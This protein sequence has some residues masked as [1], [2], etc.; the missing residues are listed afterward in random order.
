MIIDFYENFI[1][2]EFLRDKIYHFSFPGSSA[3]LN[4]VIISHFLKKNLDQDYLLRDN[5]N[6]NL[7][8]YILNIQKKHENNFRKVIKFFQNNDF[9]M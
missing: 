3:H 2:K 1:I 9:E 6:S 4:Y 8:K 5:S 7:S